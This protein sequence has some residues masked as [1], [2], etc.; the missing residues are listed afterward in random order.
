MK[1]RTLLLTFAITLA[2][3]IFAA[4]VDTLFI[5]SE[6]MNKN[7]KVLIIYP[8]SSNPIDKYP[9]FYLLHGYGGDE[10]TWI[11]IKPELKQMVDNDHI[12]VV[13]PDAENSW[14]WDSPTH[15]NSQYETFV[16]K[17]LIEYIDLHYPTKADR[18]YRAIS[19]LSMGGHGGMWL[20]IRHKNVFGA[21]GSMSGGVDIRPFPDNW[22][23]KAQLGEKKQNEDRWNN[24]TAINQINQLKDGDLAIIIDCGSDDFFLDVNKKFHQ[25]LT[26]LG[27]S[28]D[29]I[30]RPGQHDLPYWNNA[31]DY[32]WTFMKK[33]FNGYRSPIKH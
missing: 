16:S 25:K 33:F 29:F 30:I 15:K 31:I 17:E 1:K 28:H 13:C 9:V 14:Y 7:V 3:N 12:M 22:E 26:D 4:S 27:I 23:M 11:T 24:F 19:G 8:E 20:G 18:A 5:K 21:A 10:K 6:K 2:V 32:Q